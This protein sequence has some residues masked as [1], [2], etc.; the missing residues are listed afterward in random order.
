MALGLS[1]AGLEIVQS[2]D[3]WEPA[4]ETLTK[5]F[6]HPASIADL[7]DK[8]NWDEVLSKK[9][10]VISGGPP[11]QDFSIAGGRNTDG[12]RA[13]LTYSYA[14][15]V[16]RALPKFFV[17]ENVYSIVGTEVLEK[18]LALFQ[19]A[20]YSLTSEII[21]ASLVGVPQA[22]RRF[23]LVGALSSSIPNLSDYYNKNRSEKRMTVADYFGDQL[24]T[25]FYY[26]HPRSY[27][28]RAVFSVHEPSS[29]IRGVNRPMPTTYSFHPA[30][31]STNRSAIR[32][33]TTTERAQIQTFPK[34]FQFV[35][36]KS[37]SEQLVGNAVPIKLAEF[38]GAFLKT[39]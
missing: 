31:K 11:C 29:T 3:Y 19:A 32:A 10:D 39:F 22:R 24:R 33:L 28:R 27:K 6:A 12:E 13:N 15:M 18:S 30:D 37:Q 38:V 14:E 17:M 2:Y 9:F 21:D 25:D 23:I 1:N 5:N 4:H 34:S 16:T 20:G 35:E 36:S 8:A 7:S 26:A